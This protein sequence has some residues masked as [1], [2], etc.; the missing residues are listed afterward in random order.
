M[1]PNFQKL[2]IWVAVLVLLAALFNLFNSPA[3][4]RRGNEITY[5]EFIAAVDGG[6]VTEV[7]IAGN[8]IYGALSEGGQQFTTYA[9]DDRM[10]VERLEKKGIKF[11]ARPSDE[12]VPSL[13]SVLLN[14]FPMLLLIGVWVFFMRQM[15]SGSGRA[16][17]F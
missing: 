17:G 2:A 6:R 11:K 10:L 9:P 7:T 14:W 5:S 1:N 15:Q 12:D 3:Q 16:M 8:R 4:N 13:M